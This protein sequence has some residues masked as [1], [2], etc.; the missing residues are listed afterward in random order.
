VRVYVG[1]KWQEKPQVRKVQAALVEAGHEI[2]FDW[3]QDNLGQVEKGGDAWVQI[4]SLWY[5]PIR[6]G[7]Q[8]YDDLHGVQ[9]CDA[10][11]ICAMNPHKYSGTLCEMG[12]ALGLGHHV[13]IIGQCL[14]SNIF[15]WLPW[16]HVVENVEEVINALAS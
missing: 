10:I 15:T 2:T 7:M 6:L 11:V 1:G 16:V 3:T 4:Y 14:D 13:Y 12:I 5:D 8:A 9:T